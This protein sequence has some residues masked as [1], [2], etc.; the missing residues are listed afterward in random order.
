MTRSCTA[1]AFTPRVVTTGS[2]RLS[3]REREV[4]ELLVTGMTQREVGR[5]LQAAEHAVEMRLR[6]ARAKFGALTTTQL[7]YVLVKSGAI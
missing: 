7:V 4:I 3:A 2:P 6:R 5:A 1:F